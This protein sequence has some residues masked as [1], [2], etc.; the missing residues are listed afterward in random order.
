MKKIVIALF[1][2]MLCISASAQLRTSRT[3]IKKEGRPIEWILRAGLSINNMA[4]MDL[5]YYNDRYDDESISLGSKTGFAID[6]GFN[7]YFGQSNV[8][9][10]MELG[11]GTR[12]LSSTYKRYY[13]NGDEESE[14]GSMTAYTMK[15]SPFTV[16]YKIQVTDNL[17]IDPHFGIYASYDLSREYDNRY[18]FDYDEYDSDYNWDGGIQ[19][20]VGAWYGHFNLD[21][22]YQRGFVD[23]VDM[24]AV[25]NYG[26]T[27]NFLIRIGYS[28]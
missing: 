28:F 25:D 3:F 7:K 9:W 26:K 2:T 19:L 10:G 22:M 18:E 12:G 24:D 21:F 8:Y 27:S 4:G 17:K 5:D 23:A 11:I 15:F 14:K 13:G 20:G 1:A 6:F 16:G